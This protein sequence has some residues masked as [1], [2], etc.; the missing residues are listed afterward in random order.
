MEYRTFKEFVAQISAGKHLPD[1]IYLHVTA[2]DEVPAELCETTFKIA[3]ALKIPDDAWNVVKFNK[4]DFK[5]SLLNYPDF[6][7]Y[8]YPALAHSFTI[9]LSK[10]T[11]RESS[12]KSSKNP[13][14]LHRRETLVA[15]SYPLMDEFEAYTKE[16]EDIGLYEKARSI[17]FKKN[18]EKLIKSK[19]YYLDQTGHIAPLHERSGD[20]ELQ[21]VEVQRH[22]TAIDRNQLSQPMQ[23][24]ARHDY[25]DG[26]WSILD[27]G[28]GKGDDVRELEAHGLDVIGWDP[29]FYPDSDPQASEITNLGFVLNVIEER[30]E[31]DDALRRAWQLTEKILVVSVMVA[32]ESTIIQFEPYKDGVVTKLN[33]FQKYYAQSEIRLY[34]ETILDQEAIA[35]G[36]GIFF[37]FR[38]KI[39]EQEFL[40][41]R[42][43]IRR[44]W[45]YRTRKEKVRKGRKISNET[46]DDNLELFK[47]F[48]ETSL[49]L[50]RIP[51]NSEFEFSEQVRKIAGSHNQAH[52]RL[53]GYF[54]E[55]EFELAT[56]RRRDDLLVYFSLGLFSKRKPYSQMPESLK[57]DIKAFFTSH[58]LAIDEATELL[59]S[60]GSPDVIYESCTQAYNSLQCGL[61]DG[62]H[63]FTFHKSYLQDLNAP[64]RVYV[65]C[66]LTLYGEFD[67]VD[68]VKAHIGSGKV[69]FLEYD[70]W[71]NEQPALH[72][73]IKVKLR[74]QDLD[75]FDHTRVPQRI[76]NKAIYLG[77]APL[78]IG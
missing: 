23:I 67:D 35:V 24:L 10:L 65:G 27:Y 3:D 70:D 17:G 18:W 44:S 42:Q 64:L 19:G 76:E 4:R 11:M 47:D 77:K 71:S 28:C 21:E 73:R 50:G 74:E 43:H 54:D 38:D 29:N 56:K 15:S 37:V 9:D 14:I 45:A 69:T 6:E 31:R 68:L 34:I 22:K 75:F 78:V 16:G 61:L 36:Q 2:L 8:P 66:A 33:T 39:E 5:V 58:K 20:A 63:S 13:P 7:D 59:F 53:I 60:V 1:A 57:R 26:N 62:N 51:A 55:R 12:Y 72:Y 41:E 52:K 46:I 30:D 25:L 32:G 40:L 48:W 49:D